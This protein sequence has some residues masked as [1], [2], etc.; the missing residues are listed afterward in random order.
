MVLALFVGTL[1]IFSNFRLTRSQRR[2]F[3]PY[4]K[5]STSPAAASPLAAG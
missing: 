4:S 2:G 1:A 5:V 3:L